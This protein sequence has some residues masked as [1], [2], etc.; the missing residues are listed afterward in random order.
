MTARRG[1]FLLLVTCAALVAAPGASASVECDGVPD[2]RSVEGPWVAVPSL[3]DASDVVIWDVRCPNGTS[4]AGS[5][6][7][8]DSTRAGLA[9]AA[10][11]FPDLELYSG[12][13]LAFI[14]LNQTRTARTFQPLIGCQNSAGSTRAVAAGA[15]NGPTRRIVTRTVRPER[16]AVYRHRCPGGERLVRSGSGVGFFEDDSP[17]ARELADLEVTRTQRNGRVRVR[18]ETGDLV[19]DDERVRIQIHAICR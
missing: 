11:Q 17:T 18:V 15:P 3:D 5:D 13:D 2:C 4:L 6:W 1:L 8:A 9:V 7:V 12:V 19:G 14:G 10:E 16:R